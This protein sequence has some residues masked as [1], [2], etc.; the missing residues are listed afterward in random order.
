MTMIESPIAGL[1]AAV[2]TAEGAQLAAGDTLI[3]VESMKM[4]IP[5]EAQTPGVVR[6]MLVA[7][8]DQIAEGQAVAEIE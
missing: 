2:E 6:R 8:G 7:V 4:E 3:I 5:V 1:V